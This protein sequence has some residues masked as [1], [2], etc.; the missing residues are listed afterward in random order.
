MTPNDINHANEIMNL[1]NAV[2][3]AE[4][5]AARWKAKYEVLVNQDDKVT[6][7]MLEVLQWREKYQ[8]LADR[9]YRE[10]AANRRSFNI[11]LQASALRSL[12]DEIV[13][14]MQDEMLYGLFTDFTMAV[15]LKDEIAYERL[16]GIIERAMTVRHSSDGS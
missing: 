7:L 10:E 13:N 11:E 5:E 9:Y 2:T 3:E 16:K 4:M 1:S 15:R 14:L 8:D 12:H 6:P